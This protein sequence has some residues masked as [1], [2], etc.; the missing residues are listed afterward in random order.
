M[1]LFIFNSSGV[2]RYLFYIFLQIQVRSADDKQRLEEN[3]QERDEH[4]QKADAAEA[5]C[6]HA[7]WVNC[8]QSF[9]EA[10]LSARH[11]VIKK[12]ESVIKEREKCSDADGDNFSG[13]RNE[14]YKK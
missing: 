8:V 4:K 14:S 9:F 1:G 6:E 7:A 5:V 3:I 10:E 12:F 13:C 11:R 2:G